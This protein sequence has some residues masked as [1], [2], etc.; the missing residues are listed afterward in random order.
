M[1]WAIIAVRIVG[2]I[3]LQEVWGVIDTRHVYSYISR[4]CGQLQ[5]QVLWGVIAP[6]DR[7]RYTVATGV[8]G[9]YNSRWSGELNLQPW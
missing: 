3:Y 4:C 8:V 6:G 7:G 2:S 9:S 5:F 1:L